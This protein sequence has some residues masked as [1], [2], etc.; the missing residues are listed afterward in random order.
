[1]TIFIHD[2]K[3]KLLISR[4]KGSAQDLLEIAA[5]LRVALDDVDLAGLRLF[6]PELSHA[7]FVGSSFAGADLR[8]AVL[9][10]ADLRW[11]DLEGAMLDDADLKDAL[12]ARANLAG[13][14]LCNTALDSASSPYSTKP[15]GSIHHPVYGSC[16]RCTSST[17]PSRSTSTAAPSAFLA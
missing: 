10:C 9:R 5:A 13:A 4:E 3:G 8:K 6:E 15:A 16:A 1:M 2:R 14:K 12:L 11:A 7:S 17:V